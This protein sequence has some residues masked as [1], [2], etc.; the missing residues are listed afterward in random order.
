[1]E[2]IQGDYFVFHRPTTKPTT[3]SDPKSFTVY[4]TEDTRRINIEYSTK[5]NSPANYVY[6]LM[7]EAPDP[8]KQYERAPLFTRFINARMKEVYRELAIEKNVTTIVSCHTFT[9]QLKRSGMS[10]KFI[11]EALDH[12]D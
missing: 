10:T 4:I 1:M 3:R 12:T 9:I 6:H 8:W 5:N 7:D 11:Q 2:Y